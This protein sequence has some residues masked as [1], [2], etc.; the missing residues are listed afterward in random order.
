M[1]PTVEQPIL[2]AA[3]PRILR[4]RVLHLRAS[5]GS[6]YGE[7]LLGEQQ[8]VIGHLSSWIGTGKNEGQTKTVYTLKVDGDGPAPE[9]SDFA[10]FRDAYARL[11]E[12]R[13]RDK[14]WNDAAP[15][16]GDQ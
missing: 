9:F 16:G 1:T 11:L 2:N 14:E 7:E 12:Q 3:E 13:R 15:K 6:T 10:S 5:G 4:R 8:N